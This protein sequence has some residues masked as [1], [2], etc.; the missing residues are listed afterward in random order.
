MDWE[1]L[2]YVGAPLMVVLAFV[3]YRYWNATAGYALRMRESHAR[4]LE[5]PAEASAPTAPEPVEAASFEDDDPEIDD[6]VAA[7]QE[8]SVPHSG[9]RG[10]TAV[11][12]PST[13]GVALAG[14]MGVSAGPLGDVVDPAETT[15]ASRTGSAEPPGTETTNGTQ[16]TASEDHVEQPGEESGGP[17]EAEDPLVAA[18][19]AEDPPDDG[20]KPNDSG[21]IGGMTDSIAAV[22]KDLDEQLAA[23]PSGIELI[24]LPILER[25]RIADRRDELLNDRERLLEKRKR[26]AH[27]HRRGSRAKNR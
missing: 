25:R 23:L 26:G 27:R 16:E 6:S 18:K 8:A 17:K 21:Q 1:I 13:D 19:E 10:G 24:D 20:L 4:K 14:R 2:A 22:I 12:E 11:E 15:E 3:A 5:P 9:A 7:E